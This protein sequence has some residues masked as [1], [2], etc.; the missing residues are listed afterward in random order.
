MFSV[1]IAAIGC[2]SEE[3]ACLIA[4]PAYTAAG[5]IK[6]GKGHFSAQVAFF[7][8]GPEESNR[9]GKFGFAGIAAQDG[10]GG[11]ELLITAF[12]SACHGN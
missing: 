10:T 4:I 5:A 1:G 6:L 9:I 12:C 2:G 11:L 3:D 7:N 8:G